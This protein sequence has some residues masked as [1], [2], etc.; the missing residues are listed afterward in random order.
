MRL[1]WWSSSAAV[2]RTASWLFQR[3]S[4]GPVPDLLDLLV[5]EARLFADH[6]VV[7]PLVVRVAVGGGAQNEQLAITLG[8]E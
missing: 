5:G 6:D 8:Q 4:V 1:S 7:G 3:G 2:S